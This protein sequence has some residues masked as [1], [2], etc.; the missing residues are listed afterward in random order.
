MT[1]RSAVLAPAQLHQ[2]DV[3]QA[4]S[5]ASGA[6]APV[7]GSSVPGRMRSLL[8]GSSRDLITLAPD[9][10]VARERGDRCRTAA[11]PD[12][13]GVQGRRPGR[14]PLHSSEGLAQIRQALFDVHAD[15]CGEALRDGFNQRF[16]WFVDHRG[17]T[18][19]FACGRRARFAAPRS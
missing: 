15:A 1:A 9:A 12:G 7:A 2:R 10:G 14:P 16:P 19:D 18:P 11:E 6:F 4:C 17:G 8:G 13:A 3:G 5:T